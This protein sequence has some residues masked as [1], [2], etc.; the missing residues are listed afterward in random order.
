[1][2]ERLQAY[3][4]AAKAQM[5]PI[6][7][8]DGISIFHNDDVVLY[9]LGVSKEVALLTLILDDGRYAIVV[10]SEFLE[11]PVE[12]QEGALAA[13]VSHIRLGH[14]LIP[15]DV[16][17]ADAYLDMESRADFYAF[18]YYKKDIKGFLRYLLDNR[19]SLNK[20]QRIEIEERINKVKPIQ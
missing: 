8:F 9:R 2:F 15:Q 18:N 6:L 14:H 12:L 17:S 4:R 20:E 19:K 11:M 1:M 13:E 10:N 7:E 3:F 16:S 5:E